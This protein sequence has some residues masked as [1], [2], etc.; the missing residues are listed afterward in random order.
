MKLRQ[1]RKVIARSER[2]CP[3]RGATLNE[4]YLRVDRSD[5][6]LKL[7]RAW[8]NDV[9]PGERAEAMADDEPGKAF[10]LLMRTEESRW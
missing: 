1:A 3:Y 10:E 8:W 4:A 5:K 6:T 2:G 7:F 9:P